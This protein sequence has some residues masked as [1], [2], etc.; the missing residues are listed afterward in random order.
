MRFYAQSANRGVRMHAFS[1][2][3]FF[4][5]LQSLG[6]YVAVAPMGARVRAFLRE[7]R[8]AARGKPAY[9]R[10]ERAL[11]SG[12]VCIFTGLLQL[13]RNGIRLKPSCFSVKRSPRR[14]RRAL[15]VVNMHESVLSETSG[16][17]R[18]LGW[19]SAWEV[20][21]RINPMSFIVDSGS[22]LFPACV[23]TLH[24]Q[25]GARFVCIFTW[26]RHRAVR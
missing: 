14:G 19:L 18:V 23:F 17:I 3:F 25:T 2:V 9:L 4:E 15:I 11:A 12:Q 26:L 13:P 22:A 20:P 6:F 24:P 5:V 16:S 21:F 1:R 10:A 8:R 7:L